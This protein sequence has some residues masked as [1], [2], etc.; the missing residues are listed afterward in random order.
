MQKQGDLKK[1]VKCRN[2]PLFMKT[3]GQ[4]RTFP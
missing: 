3:Q 2:A 1:K 4:F